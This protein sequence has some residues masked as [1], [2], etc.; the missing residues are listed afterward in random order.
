M[1]GFLKIWGPATGLE[2]KRKGQQ[3]DAQPMQPPRQVDLLV[4]PAQIYI[5]SGGIY[6]ERREARRRCFY[7]DL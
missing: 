6:S 4:K 1:Q 5:A 7:T 3:S 2:G